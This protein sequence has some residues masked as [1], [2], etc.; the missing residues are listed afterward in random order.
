LFLLSGAAG[1]M[2]SGFALT[3]SHERKLH[4]PQTR[5]SKMI[6]ASTKPGTKGRRT[7]DEQH[8]FLENTCFLGTVFDK[9]W[10]EWQ[11]Y[12]DEWHKHGI[13]SVLKWIGVAIR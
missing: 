4:Q 10:D 5:F 6:R 8:F 3:V 13:I 9:A 12:R 2:A 11:T 7:W 1:E